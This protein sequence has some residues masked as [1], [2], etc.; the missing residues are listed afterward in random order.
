[1]RRLAVALAALAAL[2]ATA[3]DGSG[4]EARAGASSTTT[5]GPVEV[6][7]A[8]PLAAGFRVLDGGDEGYEV[9]V[10]GSWR[11][12]PFDDQAVTA[13]IEANRELNPDLARLLETRRRTAGSNLLVLDDRPPGA[14]LNVFRVPNERPLCPAEV[15]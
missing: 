8:E 9:A 12:M 3:C 13:M 10:P 14:N 4:A 1:M 7:E 6:L 11:D 2:A 5:T 15:A